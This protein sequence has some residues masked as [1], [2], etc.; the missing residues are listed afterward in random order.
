MS[1]ATVIAAPV[2]PMPSPRGPSP[3]GPVAVAPRASRPRLRLTRRGRV[4]LGV[5]AAVPIVAALL[6]GLGAPGAIAG[7]DAPADSFS[8]VS[9]AAGDSLW[10]LAESIAP[11][12][13]PRDVIA[14]MVALNQLE[15]A[16]IVPG[17]RLAIPTAY[18]P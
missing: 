5:L 4:V 2:A 14:D 9:V 7:Q 8:Y 12:A 17:Q 15:S 6:L 13:D 18:A 16:A 11:D 1:T 3:R 10:Q